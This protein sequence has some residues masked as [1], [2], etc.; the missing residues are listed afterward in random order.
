MD[1]YNVGYSY[2]DT[3]FLSS[4]YA[5]FEYKGLKK[6]LGLAVGAIVS[7]AIPFAAPLI[8]S[9]FFAGSAFFASALGSSLIGAG[10][11]AVGGAASAAIGGGNIL[12]G[13]LYGGAAGGI[14]AGVGNMMGIG[15]AGAAATGAAGAGGAG[16]T[17][18]GIEA[19]QMAGTGLATQAATG[20]AT[21]GLS[22]ALGGAGSAFT[23]ALM[24][25]V[26]GAASSL[27]TSMTQPD[28]QAY[29]KAME[30]E[31]KASEAAAGADYERKLSVYNEMLSAARNM[32][33]EFAATLATGEVLAANAKRIR[34][35]TQ[36]M[37]RV[38]GKAADPRRVNAYERAAMINSSSEAASAGTQAGLNTQ[39]QQRAAY[40]QLANASPTYN[41]GGRPSMYGA[42]Y[43]K[44]DTANKEFAAGLSGV[45]E[46][47]SYLGASK[48]K[49]AVT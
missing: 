19:A 15:G 8:A 22:S 40:S 18:T 38:G 17:S 12:Q 24:S 32:D 21:G 25:A 45:L 46:P 47:F 6:W 33:P 9:T 2:R 28:Q 13:A 43:N 20:A 14:G 34:A 7:I 35:G 27:L 37:S 11:G 41:L 42:L 31:L 26:P 10:L 23:D 1:N 16:L 5:D 44:Q 3:T 36:D 49:T 30:Q 39:S 29:L 48:Q 4:Y